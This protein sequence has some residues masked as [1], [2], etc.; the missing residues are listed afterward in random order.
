M[1]YGKVHKNEI[2]NG[3]LRTLGTADISSLL[4]L[5]SFKNVWLFC[6]LTYNISLAL[7]PQNTK[8]GKDFR[9]HIQI[10]FN[11]TLI[12][13][14]RNWDSERCTHLIQVVQLVQELKAHP[15]FYWVS[16]PSWQCH[17]LWSTPYFFLRNKLTRKHY[18]YNH[19]L[20]VI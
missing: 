5:V 11:V 4:N 3:D 19:F 10:I 8:V 6:L 15:N 17:Q 20:C 2:V 7:K 14:W 12:W 18:Y 9:G 1:N 13:R 16:F